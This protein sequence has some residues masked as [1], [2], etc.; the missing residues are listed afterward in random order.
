M[1]SSRLSDFLTER[2]NRELDRERR[3][4]AEQQVRSAAA[5]GCQMKSVGRFTSRTAVSFHDRT[6]SFQRLPIS[7]R[8]PR[9]APHTG[10][11]RGCAGPSLASCPRVPHVTLRLPAAPDIRRASTSTQ[12]QPCHALP[13]CLR[14]SPLKC[15]RPPARCARHPQGKHPN[16]VPAPEP[17]TVR[18]ISAV[19]KKCEVKPRFY[20]T[21]QGEPARRPR[22][23]YPVLPCPGACTPRMTRACAAWPSTVLVPCL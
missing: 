20:E 17:L 21:F 6:P 23:H 3:R 9:C 12:A 2:L 14:P 7:P 5:I 11:P 22:L 18:M 15:C 10:R 8:V 4:R 16:D 13:T 19:S 1:P